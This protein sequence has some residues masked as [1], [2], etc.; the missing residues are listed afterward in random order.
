M[1]PSISMLFKVCMLRWQVIQVIAFLD[2]DGMFVRTAPWGPVE[3][4]MARFKWDTLYDLDRKQFTV[5]HTRALQASM[6]MGEKVRARHRV[7]S[8]GGG[9]L[10]GRG[11]SGLSVCRS[12]VGLGR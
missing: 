5:K 2:L 4:D 11:A 7:G 10:D 3:K 8:G 6:W 12:K 9:P 1:P